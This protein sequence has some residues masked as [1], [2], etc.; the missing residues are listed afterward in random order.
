MKILIF[1][2]CLIVL[3]A[4]GCAEAPKTVRRTNFEIMYEKADLKDVMEKFKKM[5]EDPVAYRAIEVLVQNKAM[6]QIRS[7]KP[8]ET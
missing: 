4:F 7:E 8:N 6:K 5:M 1:A 3:F 2:N